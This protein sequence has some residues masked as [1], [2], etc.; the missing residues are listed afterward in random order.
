MEV[1]VDPEESGEGFDGTAADPFDSCSIQNL[2]Q[3]SCQEQW[4]FYSGRAEET[5]DS[6]VHY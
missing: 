3:T 5:I 6:M 1:R 4:H 2:K